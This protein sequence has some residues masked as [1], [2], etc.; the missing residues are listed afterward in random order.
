MA[1]D[2]DNEPEFELPPTHV[3]CALALAVLLLAIMTACH[4]TDRQLWPHPYGWSAPDMAPVIHVQPDAAG[5]TR[6]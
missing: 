6:T 4:S 1:V 3:L 2:P 5:R